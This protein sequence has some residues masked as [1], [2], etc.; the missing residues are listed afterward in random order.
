[1]IRLAI[2]VEGQ[3][4]EAFVKNVLAEHLRPMNVEP[5]PILLGRARGFHGGGHVNVERLAYDMTHLR[6]SFDAVTSLVDLYGF[7]GRGDRTV[8]ELEDQLAREIG[9]DVADQMP[10]IPYVQKHEFEALLF[11]DVTAFSAAQASASSV[12]Q[13]RQIRSQFST[14]EEIDDG[15]DTAPSRRIAGVIS[16]YG[17]LLHGPLVAMEIG[18]RKIRMECPRFDRWVTRLEKLA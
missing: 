17:K 4:E 9:E 5:T 3:T 14:P 8:E 2:S 15:P 10:V 12:A 16:H 11:S 6:R 7:A 1:M 18:L 13:L